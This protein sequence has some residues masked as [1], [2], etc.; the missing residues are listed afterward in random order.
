MLASVR[1]ADR[2]IHLHDFRLGHLRVIREVNV[3]EGISVDL[4]NLVLSLSDA[5][6]LASPELSQHQ[7]RT[8]YVAWELGKI[9]KLPPGDVEN[10]FIAS[11]LHDV[12]ALSLE[13]KIDIHRTDVV[14]PEPH[15]LIGEALL[16]E[17]PIF[18]P[19]ARIVRFH[20]R[21]WQDWQAPIDTSVVL[22]SQM[23]LVADF[24]ERAIDRR[25]YILHQNQDIIAR[26]G[27]LSGTVFHG[28]VV[29]MFRMISRRED[30]WLDLVSP[31]VY[32]LLLHHGPGRRIELDLDQLRVISELFR[33][34]IDFRSRFTATHSSGVA[35]SASTLSRLFG[36]TEMEIGL[37]EIT[38]NLHDLGKL[39]IPNS[40]LDK[41][42]KLTKEEFALM[43][44][45][46]YFTY[47]VLTTVGGIRNIAEWAAFHHEKLD[48]TGYPFHLDAKRLDV[49]SRI[50][51]VAD[52][53]T[54][55]TEDRPYRNGMRKDEVLSILRNG[56]DRNCLDS[57]VVSV[58]EKNYDEIA[59][60]TAQKQADSREYYEREFARKSRPIRR[61]R[62]PAGQTGHLH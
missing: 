30:F 44:Q 50:L 12:G 53:F 25:R 27:S 32:S 47:H 58:L 7:L 15:C 3:Y 45:H 60:F 43:Q 23:L 6:D 24:L 26:I 42:D 13:E 22:Q 21:E 11:L 57:N 59:S 39:V 14:D 46:A 38:G 10:L 40:I 48:G 56:R 17:V 20:H 4:L 61:V 52:M 49:N 1:A 55:L 36:L 51:A 2:F 28:Q 62:A 9:A 33:N 34:M 41:P 8:A 16:K 5:M 35:A 37:M 19:C 54:A 18:E 29:D 31:R